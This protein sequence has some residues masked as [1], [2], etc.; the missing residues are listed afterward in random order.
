MR[1]QPSPERA[2]LDFLCECGC[3]GPVRL[4]LDQYVAAG[5]RLPGHEVAA[6]ADA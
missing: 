1:F 2:V 5:A 6:P 3:M 4:T